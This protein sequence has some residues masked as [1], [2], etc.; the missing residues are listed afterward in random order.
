MIL[1]Y[2]FQNTFAAPTGRVVMAA[3][4]IIALNHLIISQ[5]WIVWVW[6]PHGSHVGQVKFYLQVCQ[7]IFP[8]VHPFSPHL[9]IGLSRYEWNNLKRHV[10]LNKKKRIKKPQSTIK[11]IFEPHHNQ[12]VFS[13]CKKK[14]PDQLHGYHA[15]DQCFCFPFIDFT[16]LQFSESEISNLQPSSL[17]AQPSLSRSWSDTRKQKCFFMMWLIFKLYMMNVYLQMELN[18]V[19]SQFQVRSQTY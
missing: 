11:E 2:S 1:I 13:L 17:S 3:G 12:P 16:I 10:K 5:L 4:F 18:A 19:T 14:D 9:L 15:A 6:T 7:V 8:R